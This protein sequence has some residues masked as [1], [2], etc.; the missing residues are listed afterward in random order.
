MA[1]RLVEIKG[2]GETVSA[3]R[4]ALQGV[5]ASARAMNDTAAKLKAE[6]EDV[7]AQLQEHRDDL[8][9]DAESLGNA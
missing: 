4:Q 1:A 6:V 9:A 2:L 7:T 3:A 8:K 5:R